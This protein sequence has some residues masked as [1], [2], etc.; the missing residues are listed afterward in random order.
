[1]GGSGGGGWRGHVAGGVTEVAVTLL[2]D[3]LPTECT[4]VRGCRNAGSSS[5]SCLSLA[6]FY[7]LYTI[8]STPALMN[9]VV[10]TSS[11]Q[12]T[13]KPIVWNTDS[14]LLPQW[15]K[16]EKN[17][18]ESQIKIMS[19]S[20]PSP[21]YLSICFSVTLKPLPV[22]FVNEIT[23]LCGNVLL[24]TE[25]A[26]HFVTALS[27]FPPL[28]LQSI[29]TILTFWDSRGSNEIAKSLT[30]PTSVASHNIIV[31]LIGFVVNRGLA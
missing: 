24:S 1:M 10:I 29:R 27:W 6:P 11:P 16:L 22:S 7:L 18:K 2:N 15:T 9:S 20:R 25:I 4:G 28:L 26:N 8:I 30:G 23:L 21:T 14:C 17:T 12:A 31:T 19:E 5:S 13:N 3:T